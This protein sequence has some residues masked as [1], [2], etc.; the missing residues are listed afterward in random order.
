MP[1]WVWK[2]FPRKTGWSCQELEK[3]SVFDSAIFVAEAF[4]GT[5]G[6][7]VDIEDT[8]DGFSKIIEGEVDDIPESAFSWWEHWMKR[9]KR[10]K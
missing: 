3:S 5:S 4:T 7:F 1:F 8:I 9:G 6:R 2:N 10:L